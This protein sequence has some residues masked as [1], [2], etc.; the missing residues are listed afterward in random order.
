MTDLNAALNEVVMS[1]AVRRN[2]FIVKDDSPKASALSHGFLATVVAELVKLGYVADLDQLKGLS[3][4]EAVSLLK[5]LSKF[6]GTN[7]RWVPFY[8][9]FPQQV[10]ESSESDL[11]FNALIHYLSRGTV[12][13]VENTP[14]VARTP[15]VK[16]GE[17]SLA[18]DNLTMLKGVSVDSL[19]LNVFDAFES[20]VSVS[21]EIMDEL[22]SLLSYASLSVV[23]KAVDGFETKNK[24]NWLILGQAI[25]GDSFDFYLDTA[26]TATDV[27][28]AVVFQSSLEDAIQ[29]GRVPNLVVKLSRSQR[30]SVMLTLDKLARDG[31]MSIK[32]GQS[33]LKFNSVLDDMYSYKKLWKRISSSLHPFDFK[34]QAPV[35]V[36]VYS[37]VLGNDNAVYKR[38][39]SIVEQKVE[40][41]NILDAAALL[42]YKPGRFVRSY[43][44]LVRSAKDE[45][46][47]MKVISIFNT[48]KTK[49][50][51]NTLISAYNGIINRDKTH[52]T[53]R[54]NG[55]KHIERVRELPS[56]SPD[57]VDVMLN[58]IVNKIRG[59]NFDSSQ[60]EGKVFVDPVLK[61]ISVPLNVRDSSKG[62]V[63]PSGSKVKLGTDS[64]IIRMFT[65]WENHKTR[66]DIDLSAVFYGENSDN[67]DYVNYTRLKNGF[68][69]HSGDYVDAPA[70]HGATEF[71]DIDVEKALAAGVRYVEMDIRSYAG[72]P[73][74]EMGQEE[75]LF[76]GVSFPEDGQTG[77]LFD[78]AHNPWSFTPSGEAKFSMSVFVFD[79]VEGEMMWV[80][81]NLSTGSFASGVHQPES[82]SSFGVISSM[83]NSKFFSLYDLFVTHLGEGQAVEERDEAD[84]VVS[85]G[86]SDVDIFDSSS[87]MAFL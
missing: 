73:L 85:I 9:N 10:M 64:P 19:F 22:D 12:N 57:V 72:V 13:P 78:L 1:A 74:K 50:Q 66:V 15:V 17:K 42:S 5:A 67:K 60:L 3:E 37:A 31:E 71:V 80:D 52:V 77:E 83:F 62:R 51:T 61:G 49:I 47:A 59:N 16:V 46:E 86:D 81:G 26:K 20:P 84:T 30:K 41:G 65:H 55:G 34:R 82:D 4:N 21:P 40:E 43:D 45:N 23:T 8:P 18:F 14:M 11:V 75:K 25:E 39:N 79:L 54:V 35:A 32:K 70:P 87:L 29:L 33:S 2:V 44:W 68:A 24:E 27:L 38:F 56:I 7:L 63:L 28:R 36:D 58:S 53:T 69:V 6:K 48:L 76:A